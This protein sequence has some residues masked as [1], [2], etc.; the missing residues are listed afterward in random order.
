MAYVILL[1]L[2]FGVVY[3]ISQPFRRRAFAEAVGQEIVD[4]A[5]PTEL[6][7]L[8]AA[9]D[10]KYREIRDAELDHETGKLSDDDY[11]A[12]N[13][14]LRTEAVALLRQLDEFHAGRGGLEEARQVQ[15]ASENAPSPGIVDD[16]SSERASDNAPSAE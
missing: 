8:E 11:D 16:V 1:I 13:S 2:L 9:R 4:D 6:L 15:G 7:E 10:A 14:T 3:L 5:R 12:I